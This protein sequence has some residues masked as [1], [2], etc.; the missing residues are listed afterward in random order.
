MDSAPKQKKLFNFTKPR[1]YKER[2]VLESDYV[3]ESLFRRDEQ[4]QSVAEI[5]YPLG[6][7]GKPKNTLI[8][9][10][11]GSGKTVT[12][13]HVLNR[14]YS[15]LPDVNIKDITIPCGKHNTVVKILTFLIKS[16]DYEK[17][18]PLR[19]V[20][21]SFF[22]DLFYEL[23]R[24]KRYSLTVIFDEIDKI[25]DYNI[26]Y[27]FSRA[28]EFKELNE[29]QYIHII[30]ISNKDQFISSLYRRAVSSF[31]QDTIVFPPYNEEQIIDILNSRVPFAFC[32]K[33]VGKN[34]IK[35]CAQL[36]AED[37]GDARRAILLLQVAGDIAIKTECNRVQPGHVLMAMDKINKDISYQF[38]SNM[39]YGEK[40][41][42]LAL[43][44]TEKYLKPGKFVITGNVYRVYV[45]MCKKANIEPTSLGALS[46]KITKFNMMGILNA[47]VT[48]RGR[49]G[50]TS[51]IVFISAPDSLEE[52]IYQDCKF[53][54]FYNYVPNV[55]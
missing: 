45:D 1:I 11:P 16:L 51:E 33:V 48:S 22:Y 2:F 31:Q 42:I 55:K 53:V 18:L 10:P 34:V 50:Q 3:P 12:I 7:K 24:Q 54:K 9:G 46:Q 14:L 39:S 17:D 32:P 52:A 38:V 6:D 28:E 30:G 36:A 25:Q 41:V 5:Y 40:L 49:G 35:L 8:Y 47:T 13:R 27:N 20:A 4:I 23:L 15:E 43:I 21:S 37:E 19:G 44:K 29:R 26:I